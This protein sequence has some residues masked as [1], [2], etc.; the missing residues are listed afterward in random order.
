MQQIPLS[1]NCQ[2]ARSS[3]AAAD[4]R[5]PSKTMSPSSSLC[6]QRSCKPIYNIQAENPNA[7][8]VGVALLAAGVGA[9]LAA[10]AATTA[11]EET[12]IVAAQQKQQ[13]QQEKT[14]HLQQQKQHRL[15]QQKNHLL[16]QQRQQQE[17][18]QQQ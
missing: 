14:H 15:Q 18:Q 9:L 17:H 1:V 16:Q 13:Q 5:Q 4:I 6:K 8:A 11:A 3:A 12:I 10:A 7:T 2:R